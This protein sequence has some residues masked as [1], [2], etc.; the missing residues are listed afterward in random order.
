[1]R[2]R[3]ADARHLFQVGAVKNLFARFDRHLSNTAYRTDHRRDRLDCADVTRKAW[4]KTGI[5]SISK[6]SYAQLEGR[7]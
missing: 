7:S 3:C 4:R 2:G 1:M 5:A 6:R